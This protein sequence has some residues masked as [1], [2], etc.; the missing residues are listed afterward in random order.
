MAQPAIQC[1]CIQHGCHNGN[2]EEGGVVIVNGLGLLLNLLLARVPTM[3]F[4][5][6]RTLSYVMLSVAKSPVGLLS[7][8]KQT[9]RSEE[10]EV[11]RLRPGATIHEARSLEVLCFLRLRAIHTHIA[12]CNITESKSWIMMDAEL[13]DYWLE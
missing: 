13:A 6:N 4:E 1:E 8:C 3:N 9:E 10:A 2:L 5:G 7:R 12:A 11:G